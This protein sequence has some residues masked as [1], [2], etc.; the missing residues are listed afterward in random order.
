MQFVLISGSFLTP[1]QRLL[2]LTCR[3]NRKL[4]ID[5]S[6][7]SSKQDINCIQGVSRL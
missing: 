1:V 3:L 4:V 2:D 5:I 6:K 7:K